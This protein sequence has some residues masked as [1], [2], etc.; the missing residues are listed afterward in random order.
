VARELAREMRA[1]PPTDEAL[2]AVG[3]SD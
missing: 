3:L 1:L 2:A